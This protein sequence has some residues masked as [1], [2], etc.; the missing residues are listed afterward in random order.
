MPINNPVKNRNHNNRTSENNHNNR[1]NLNNRYACPARTCGDFGDRPCGE[2][3]S[4][5]AGTWL[6]PYG[7]VPALAGLEPLD[8]QYH[9]GPKASSL[10]NPK[11]KTEPRAKPPLIGRLM[12]TT[13]TRNSHKIELPNLSGQPSPFISP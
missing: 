3:G 12:A 7:S 13:I 9:S 5:S 6:V 2:G 1:I 8:E 10:S 11:V 4:D